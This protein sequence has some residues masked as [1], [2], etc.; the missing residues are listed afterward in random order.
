MKYRFSI[1]TVVAALCF[2]F[3][4]AQ[5]KNYAAQWK[6]VDALIQKQNLPKSALAEVR[7][8]YD[9]AKKEGQEAQV[10]KALVYTI[11]LQSEN[12]EDNVILSIKEVERELA[13]AKEPVASILRSLLADLHWKYFQGQR[14]KIYER[15][16]TMEFKKDDLAT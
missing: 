14:W 5:V 13:V 1:L 6:R 4:S 11:G 3:S 2:T 10:I 12:R 9:L 7:K 16:N 15:T 8:I